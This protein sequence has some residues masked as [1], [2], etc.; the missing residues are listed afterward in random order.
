VIGLSAAAALA[1]CPAEAGD[2]LAGGGGDDR[3]CAGDQ[4][5]V[6]E[7]FPR[8]STSCTAALGGAEKMPRWV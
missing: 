6:S 7:H 2:I 4:G 1:E 8:Y 3:G 5:N